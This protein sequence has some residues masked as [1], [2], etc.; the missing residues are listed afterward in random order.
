MIEVNKT[1][2]S[3]LTNGPANIKEAGGATV[4]DGPDA[5]NLYQIVMFQKMLAIEMRTGMKCTRGSLLKAVN[6]MCGTNF[7]TK[8]AAHVYLTSLIAYVKGEES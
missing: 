7:R 1:V 2:A 8:N 6:A 5:I 4:F 3:A